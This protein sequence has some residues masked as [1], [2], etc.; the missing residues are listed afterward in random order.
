MQRR[1]RPVASG[2]VSHEQE[3]V[4]ECSLTTT[5][6]MI[7][8]LVVS[9]EL[10]GDRFRI[11]TSDPMPTTENLR[12]LIKEL[13]VDVSVSPTTS[14]GMP[15]NAR[16]VY[17][18]KPLSPRPKLEEEILRVAEAQMPKN[19]G[20]MNSFCAIRINGCYVRTSRYALEDFLNVQASTLGSRDIYVL[21][22]TDIS[23]SGLFLSAANGEF[24]PFS[25]NTILE[26]T[27]RPSPETD[28]R[29][30]RFV[31]KVVRCVTSTQSQRKS[32]TVGIG[33][34]I[35]EMD[36]E[37]VQAWERCIARAAE[38]TRQRSL[39]TEQHSA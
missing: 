37:T 25:N 4:L 36:H 14:K 18:V 38:R 22:S 1:N 16:Y 23:R 27:V 39:A 35:V 20:E 26:L 29:P 24:L 10:R 17:D 32:G 11:W 31:G 13:T 5:S 28:Q 15:T 2:P 6:G 19:G 21:Q 30:L 9:I 8:P 7:K 3:I 33:I 34:Q 12:L